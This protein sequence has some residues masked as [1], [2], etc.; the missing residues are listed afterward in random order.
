[1]LGFSQTAGYAIRALACL[2]GPGGVPVQVRDVAQ[3]T[4]I[5]QPYLAKLVHELAAAGIVQTRR[6]NKGGVLLAREA[7]TLSLHDVM[8]AIEGEAYL[9][10][11]LL[12]W[13]DCT[14]EQGCP[15][16]DFWKR[17]REEMRDDLARI[18]LDK[19]TGF[20]RQRGD[21][22]CGNSCPEGTANE[23]KG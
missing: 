22:C 17:T 11:C 16:H 7:D 18:T 12:G 8:Q 13:D 2:P 10:R 3:C 23:P 14:D 21:L 4:G 20:Q 19:V 1:M 9:D 6:G 5:A 15:M